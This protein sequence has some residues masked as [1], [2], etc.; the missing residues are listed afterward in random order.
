MMRCANCRQEINVGAV[1]CPFC[2]HNPW[3]PAYMDKGTREDRVHTPGVEV[4]VGLAVTGLLVIP[5]L[6][7]VGVSLAV[8][9]G[10]GTVS[11]VVRYFR[12]R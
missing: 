1:Q 3:Y 11:A 6:P 7:V 9:G 5:A 12:G 10:V 8:S 2:R 4:P